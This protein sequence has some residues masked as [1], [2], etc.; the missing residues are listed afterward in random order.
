MVGA[1]LRLRVRGNMD[2]VRG[3]Q[4]Q[5]RG[6]SNRDTWSR[7]SFLRWEWQFAPLR[8]SRGMAGVRGGRARQSTHHK[9]EQQLRQ[10]S[11]DHPLQQSPA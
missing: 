1:R 10:S 7:G 5:S 4:G 3:W 8:R 2:N 6:Q 9:P 11:Y